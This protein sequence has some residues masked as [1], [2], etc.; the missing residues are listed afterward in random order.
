MNVR[1]QFANLP[2]PAE[3]DELKQVHI[4]KYGNDDDQDHDYLLEN[5][6]VHRNAMSDGPGFMGD[7]FFII[8]PDTSVDTVRKSHNSLR[9][10]GMVFDVSSD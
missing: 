8:Y 2:T 6:V 1:P 5:V 3:R 9:P 4:K 7:I 10:C